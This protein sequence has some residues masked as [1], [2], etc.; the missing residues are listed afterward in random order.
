MEMQLMEVARRIK[1]LREISGI[2]VEEMARVTSVTEQ[3]Y[4]EFESG[5]KDFTFTF[6]YKCAHRFGTDVTDLLAGASPTLA[7]YNVNRAGEGLPIARRK[8][9]KYNNLAPLFKNKKA[10][11]FRVLARWSAEE[12][13]APIKLSTHSGQEYD[14]ILSGK[15]RVSI[16]GHEEILGPGDSI[17]Y[18]SSTPHGMVAVG[19]DCDFIAM[20]IDT[21]S[22]AYDYPETVV[23][24]LT[25]KR[26]GPVRK[27]A[28]DSV[29]HAF[30]ETVTDENGVLQDIKFKNVEKYNFVYDTVDVLAKKC[31][32]KTAM[33]HVD[34]DMEKVRRIT[35]ADMARESAR[36]ARYFAS[37]GIKR[38]DRVML[39]LK[40]H[41]HF[42]Y[43]ILALHR[44]GA[45]AIPATNQLMQ[46]DFEYRYKVASVNAI[47]CTA[48]GD[49]AEHAEAAAKVVEASPD[50]EGDKPIILILADGHDKGATR[51]NWH[52]FNKEYA[53][54]SS[55]DYERPADAIC[56]S[57]TMLMYF[58][59]GT[60]GYPKAVEHA[61]SYALSHYVTAR[62][63]QNVNPDGLHFTISDTGWG[64]ALWGKLYGQWL[65]EAPV[66]TFDFDRFSAEEI[67]PMFAKYRITTF[68]APPTMY[69]YFIKENLA[70]YDM[71]SLE[72]A[73][74]AGE[75][76]NPEVF[77][78]WTRVTGVP[79]MEGFG[80]TETTLTIANFVGTAPRPG[81]MGKPSPIYDI[82]IIT[83]DGKSAATGETGEIVI[84]TDK[85]TPPGL[86][87]GYYRNADGTNASWHDGAYHTGDTAWR[88]EDGYFHFVGR[89]DD[90]IK[91]SGY[92]IGPFEIESV[93]MELPYV[94][95]CAVTAA[96]DEIR[97]QVVKATIVLVKGKVGD[98]A[99]KK[100]IQEYVKT[101]T[102]PYKYPR[103]VEFV[104][105]LPK[106]ISGKIRRVELR[107]RDNA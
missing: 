32:D 52:D 91:S 93:I 40:R 16:D 13:N 56:G 88:D 103:I 30:I 15:L 74:V 83:P 33:L 47:V 101:H 3:A 98:D 19:G 28:E 12:E 73:A 107:R 11:P 59:S 69:R 78:Q 81:S 76:L 105:E 80:Q 68:C 102:A 4:R 53:A 87:K 77:E 14:F 34:R 104:T 95:E 1:E 55:D 36:T 49:T 61:C 22:G 41:Y 72:Y 50:Y 29:A 18:D 100:E 97:G 7:T 82:D 67:L 48:D 54:F 20:I 10:E 57:D 84:K 63:W 6:I 62:Y 58:T 42:W 46:H 37:L 86:F 31:P 35:F 8:G 5:E 66:F 96:P 9:F 21:G 79:L 75:A 89:V 26:T 2:S 92:R 70:S 71:S 24:P 43:S 39:V 45:I 65:A 90:V 85:S 60:S 17:Y 25:R 44:L 23:Q 51:E 94:L 64:K 27:D 99:L 38:G 106:T